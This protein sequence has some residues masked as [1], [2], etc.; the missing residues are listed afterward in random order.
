MVAKAYHDEE[1]FNFTGLISDRVVFLLNVACVDGPA[2]VVCTR[3]N[4]RQD[5]F[6][7]ARNSK[8]GS[9]AYPKTL[10]E[11]VSTTETLVNAAGLVLVI[12]EGKSR[13]C[14]STLPYSTFDKTSTL[15]QYIHRRQP[16]RVKSNL[17]EYDPLQC[18]F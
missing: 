9:L 7:W 1:V 8:A 4:M 17:Y 10:N 14:Y 3:I 13:R 2:S 18:L 16:W 12:A 11:D 5:L 6:S 15:M